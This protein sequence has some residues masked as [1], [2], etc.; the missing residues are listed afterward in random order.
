VAVLFQGRAQ[1]RIGFG[2]AGA[3]PFGVRRQG[4]PQVFAGPG[5]DPGLRQQRLLQLREHLVDAR[6]A[7]R[8]RPSSVASS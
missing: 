5:L 8:P 1:R 6:L 2:R 7:S 4:G 3:E